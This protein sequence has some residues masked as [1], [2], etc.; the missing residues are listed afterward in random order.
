MIEI[1]D[2][3]TQAELTAIFGRYETA[4][5]ADDIDALNGFFWD[6]ERTI[7]YALGVNSY[8]H[9]EIE[10]ARRARPAE[11][12]SL[13]RTVITTYGTDYGTADTEF[14]RTKSGRRGRQSQT[15]VR[16]DHGWR[17]TSAHVSWFDEPS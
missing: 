4:L 9:G 2:P 17:I 3:A 14:T 1:N 6:D 11:A 15:W 5:M 13:E 12:R 10:A 7:R 8:G 16:F